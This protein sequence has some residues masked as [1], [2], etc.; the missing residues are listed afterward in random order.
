MLPADAA[1]LIDTTL[2]VVIVTWA[3]TALLLW[4]LAAVVF[5][6]AI[7]VAVGLLVNAAR[8]AYR[9]SRFNRPSRGKRS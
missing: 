6:G 3:A 9:R 4:L 8:R 7:N 5:T 2:F 1:A